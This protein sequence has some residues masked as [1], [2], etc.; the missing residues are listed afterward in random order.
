[1]SFSENVPHALVVTAHQ[2]LPP[3]QPEAPPAVQRIQRV[4]S[5]VALEKIAQIQ[6]KTPFGLSRWVLLGIYL[7]YAFLAGPCYWNW[8][9]FADI[10][11][12]RGEYVWDCEPNTL[13]PTK[14]IQQPKC[15][16]QDVSVQRLFTITVACDFSFS[17]LAGF[18]LDY[19]G[20]RL[21]G[22]TGTTILLLAW[23]LLGA[24]DETHP[25]LIPGVILWGLSFSAAFFPCLSVSN[26]F[27]TSRNTVIGLLGAFRTLSNATPLILRSIAMNNPTLAPRLF[28]GYGGLCIGVCVIIATLLFPTRQWQVL[29]SLAKAAGLVPTDARTGEGVTPTSPSEADAV[30]GDRGNVELIGGGRGFSRSLSTF[31]TITLM[32]GGDRDEDQTHIDLL[33]AAVLRQDTLVTM[34]RG[35]TAAMV[36]RRADWQAFL[37]EA[38]SIVFIPLCVY[39]ALML[40]SNSFFSSAAR[41]LLPAAYEANQIIQIFAFL[42]AP[43]LGLLADKTGI[44]VTMA[45]LNGAGLLAF[46]LAIIPEVPAAVACQYLASLCIAVNSSFIISQVYCYINQS[47]QEGHAGKLIGLACLIAG[48]PSLAANAMLSTAVSEGFPNIM[49]LCIGFLSVNFFLIGGLAAARRQR[50]QRV[51]AETEV[52]FQP[53]MAAA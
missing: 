27:P 12:L 6:N 46:I 23:C 14:G 3:L 13:D 31:R 29:P 7:L 45:V 5:F 42:P 37:Q 34:Q 40:L 33:E 35:T 15:D 2:S 4:P 16:T 8:T 41:H 10:F 48:L 52:A 24:A 26:L 47:F 18:L 50:A 30:R 53:D 1:M 20:P 9:A 22:V 25:T 51:L 43:L 11:F 19:A 44:L 49:A 21:T 17:C 38:C 32:A 36:S 39:E 28:Y